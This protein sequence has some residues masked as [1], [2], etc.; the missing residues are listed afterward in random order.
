[1]RTITRASRSYSL[2]KK[3]SDYI[4]TIRKRMNLLFTRLD[5][6]CKDSKAFFP[7]IKGLLENIK[8][9]TCSKR[10]IHLMEAKSFTEWI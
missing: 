9:A 8:N 4:C 7:I 6:E 10:I 1:M 5:D 2:E 3:E